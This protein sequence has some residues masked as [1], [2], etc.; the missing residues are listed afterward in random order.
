MTAWKG[1]GKVKKLRHKDFLLQESRHQMDLQSL[2]FKCDVA[3]H[4]RLSN[5]KSD[6]LSRLVEI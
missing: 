4:E 5:D 3:F 6:L 2:H 1:R